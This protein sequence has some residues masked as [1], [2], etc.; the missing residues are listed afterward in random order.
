LFESSCQSYFSAIFER[1]F[2]WNE[3]HSGAYAGEF[4][5]KNKPRR[6]KKSWEREFSNNL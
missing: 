1:F 4:Q 2:G 3:A 5:L 6:A